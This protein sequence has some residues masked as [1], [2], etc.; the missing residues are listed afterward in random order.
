MGVAQTSG[1]R[2]NRTHETHTMTAQPGKDLLLKVDATSSGAF[3]TVAGIRSRKIAFNLATVDTTSSES[4]GQWRE[5]LAGGGVRTANV[6][7]SGIFK[8]AA[9]DAIVR[10]HMFAGTIAP[11]QIVIPTFGT[12]QGPFQVHSFDLTGKHDG[13]VTFD[14]ALESAGEITFTPSA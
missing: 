13:E 1:P 12:I 11:W 9:S 14:I 2:V 3:T 5:L 6:S 4:A 8:N 7:G 10:A